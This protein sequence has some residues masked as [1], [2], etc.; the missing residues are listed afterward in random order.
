MNKDDK[1]KP[2]HTEESDTHEITL[3]EFKNAL[4]NIMRASRQLNREE[5]AKKSKK[6]SDP[7]E[8]F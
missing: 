8:L 3:D 4:G 1:T 7:V 6:K 5:K 2:D